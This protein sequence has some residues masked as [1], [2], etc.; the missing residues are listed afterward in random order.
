MGYHFIRI[1]SMGRD[2]KQGIQNDDRALLYKH[3]RSGSMLECNVLKHGR[4][5]RQMRAFPI[6]KKADFRALTIHLGGDKS[7]ILTAFIKQRQR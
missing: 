6:R 3:D 5:H 1:T 2:D 4:I 7:C